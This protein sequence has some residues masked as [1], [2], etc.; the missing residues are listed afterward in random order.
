MAICICM[1]IHLEF[2]MISWVAS[3]GNEFFFLLWIWGP[4]SERQK[5]PKS[6]RQALE[7][8]VGQLG[9]RDVLLTTTGYGGNFQADDDVPG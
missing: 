4:P 6:A 8:Y 7:F 5:P 3:E 1:S 9:G 2:V